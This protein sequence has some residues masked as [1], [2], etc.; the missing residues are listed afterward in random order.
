MRVFGMDNAHGIKLPKKGHYS[1]KVVYDH[2]H[3]TS[4]DKG[5][6]YEFISAGQLIEDFFKHVDEVIIIREN[7]G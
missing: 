5:H 6:P 3:R 2:L 4:Y 1:G 7:R